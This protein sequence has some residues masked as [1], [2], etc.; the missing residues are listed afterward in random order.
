M[1]MTELLAHTG[2]SYELGLVKSIVGFGDS[3]SSQTTA[4]NFQCPKGQLLQGFAAQQCAVNKSYPSRAL[5]NL[6]FS[7][8]VPTSQL[9]SSPIPS[10]Q[11][12]LIRPASKPPPPIKRVVPGSAAKRP[13]PSRPVHKSPTRGPTRNKRKPPPP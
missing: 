10:S 1:I 13:P 12:G 9:P 2:N 4:F 3:T 7:C 11:P 8:T 6:R 5:C